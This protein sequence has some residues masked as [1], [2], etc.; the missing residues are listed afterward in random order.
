MADFPDAIEVVEDGDTFA[1]NAELKAVQQARHL[2]LWVLADDSGLAVDAL[3]G[4]PG[5]ISARYS[6]PGATDDSNNL[7]L[8]DALR[9]VP[10]ERRGARFVCHICL[11]D[12]SGAVE[13]TSSASCRG[14][15]LPAASGRGGF[16]YDPLFEIVE[17]HRSFG[18]L[19]PLV[20]S[21]LSHRSRAV[22]RI[23]PRL[24]EL[25]GK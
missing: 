23:L 6:G 12:P 3:N 20:K 24:I 9:D 5:V 18:D 22:A 14:R 17:Y 4:A 7:K 11:A 21:H 15:I 1:A 19:S 16:G 10:P 2:G 13:G 25:L 8:L